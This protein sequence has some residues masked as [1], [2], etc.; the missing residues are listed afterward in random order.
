MFPFV[1]FSN[2]TG[3]RAPRNRA[4]GDEFRPPVLRRGETRRNREVVSRYVRGTAET[5]EAYTAIRIAVAPRRN[6]CGRRFHVPLRGTAAN[7]NVSGSIS[8]GGATGWNQI[9][10]R[11]ESYLLFLHY[12]RAYSSGISVA[13][14]ELTL[15][16]RYRDDEAASN[17]LASNIETLGCV[18][19][20]L[21]TIFRFVLFCNWLLNGN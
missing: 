12:V 20:F 19:S 16:Y 5:R 11:G 7:S 13:R 9:I 1:P 4:A 17:I 2:A 15:E 18:Q 14:S 10:T 21:N 3:S 8:L 6:E